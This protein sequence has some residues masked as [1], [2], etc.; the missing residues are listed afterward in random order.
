M[1]NS[2]FPPGWDEAKVRRVLDHYERQSEDEAVT[3]DEA[4]FAGTRP[5]R[6]PAPHNVSPAVTPALVRHPSQRRVG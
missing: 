1:K 3:E 4:A 2:T 5:T 6:K